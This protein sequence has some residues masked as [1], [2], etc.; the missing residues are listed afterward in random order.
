M[1]PPIPDLAFH[2]EE[3]DWTGSVGGTFPTGVV[4]KPYLESEVYLASKTDCT[5]EISAR[6]S[7]PLE[8]P[9]Q[10][11]LGGEQIDTL[12]FSSGWAYVY[13]LTIE[14]YDSVSSR[15]DLPAYRELSTNGG[16]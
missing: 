12:H 5:V 6:S 9:V 13:N 3:I 11:Y 8:S 4:D 2:L 16:C 15:L 7:G 1:L 14:Y 10:V